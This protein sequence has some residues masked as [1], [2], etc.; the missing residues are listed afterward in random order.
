MGFPMKG[1]VELRGGR[2]RVNM[3]GSEQPFSPCLPTQDP[4]PKY[5]FLSPELRPDS[6]LRAQGWGPLE[7]HIL[8]RIGGPKLED[9]GPE[10]CRLIGLHPRPSAWALY[11][12]PSNLDL[13]MNDM[14][15]LRH[16]QDKTHS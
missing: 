2:A 11:G 15:K 9:R 16:E 5:N 10:V 4:G 8:A 13:P 3:T 14:R 7:E 12:A 6:P 1:P